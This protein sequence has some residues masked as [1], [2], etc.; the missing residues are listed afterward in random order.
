MPIPEPKPTE[1]QQEF[2]QRC[3]ADDVMNKEFPD[4]KQRLSVC[5]AQWTKKM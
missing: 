2:V 4:P 5:Y 1:D 3:M